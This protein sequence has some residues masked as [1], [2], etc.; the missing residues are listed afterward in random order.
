MRD[1]SLKLIIWLIHLLGKLRC[2]CHSK[3]CES[4][5][6]SGDTKKQN[7]KDFA[8]TLDR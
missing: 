3:C 1:R 6:V 7:I 5:C 8:V 4:D 2:K